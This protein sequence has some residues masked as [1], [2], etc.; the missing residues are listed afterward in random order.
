MEIANEKIKQEREHLSKEY[1]NERRELYR[2]IEGLRRDNEALRS[3]KTLPEDRKRSMK[4]VKTIMKE[5]PLGYLA[6]GIVN[7]VKGIFSGIV[8]SAAAEGISGLV[9]PSY[10]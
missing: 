4:K 9:D 8:T 10:E 1:A 5:S 6:Y 7:A 2:I 3:Q